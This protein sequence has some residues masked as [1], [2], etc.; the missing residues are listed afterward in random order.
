[1]HRTTVWGATLTAV[2]VVM[3][4]VAGSLSVAADDRPP[5]MAPAMMAMFD[6]NGDQMISRDELRQHFDARFDQIDSDHSGD[7][8]LDEF[9][10]APPDMP[11][12][13]AGAPPSGRGPDDR[14]GPKGP[15]PD[16]G[17]GPKEGRQDEMFKA[18]DRNGDG[19]V[20]REEFHDAE[21]HRFEAL[22][23]NGDGLI[24]LDELEAMP[25][26]GGPPPKR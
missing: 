1:M 16:G 8:S 17:R 6:R 23:T 4:T 25:M 11:K 7:L 15:P 3:L 10:A 21:R 19:I 26:P 13:G 22:D 12:G 18:M 9:K 20:S 14:S 5:S 24:S 2:G